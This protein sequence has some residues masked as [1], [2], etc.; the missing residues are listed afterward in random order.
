MVVCHRHHQ[1][2]LATARAH[3]HG[4]GC[5]GALGVDALGARRGD[6]GRNDLLLFAAE[7]AAFA[8]MRVEA[9]HGDA[10]RLAA[11]I[12]DAQ[13]LEH[14]SESHRVDRIAQREVD[15]HQHDAQLLVGQH[16]ANRHAAGQGL[17]HLGVARIGDARG[18]QRRL[19]QRRRDQARALPAL[20][21]THRRLDARGG[22]RA[23]TR[24]DLAPGQLIEPGRQTLGLP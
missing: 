18:G 20:H 17:Q 7:Q 14:S 4:V 1:V 13:G 15:R 3:E 23:G 21:R 19:V 12:R 10:Q 6:G 9:S 11:S 5:K 24:I 2:E 22:R 8:G 16:H